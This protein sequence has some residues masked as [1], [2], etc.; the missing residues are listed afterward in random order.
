MTLENIPLYK[1]YKNARPV[2]SLVLCNTF[3]IAI[4]EPLYI[5]DVDGVAVVAWCTGQGYDKIRRHTIHETAAGRS[6]IR[7]GGA[8]YYLDQFATRA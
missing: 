6:Y 5:D 1:R 4:L 7:K 2:A 3:S 8:R